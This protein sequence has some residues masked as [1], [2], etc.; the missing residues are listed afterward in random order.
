MKNRR[1]LLVIALTLMS[2]L[3]VSCQ[4]K[5]EEPNTTAGPNTTV[6]TTTTE[7]P[8]TT[9]NTQAPTTTT[10]APV[11]TTQAPVTNTQ[12]P[13][14]T[15]QDTGSDK[16]SIS[17]LM[18]GNSHSDDTNEWTWQILNDLGYKNILIGTMYIPGCTIEY[19]YFNAVNN[20]AYYE[21]RTTTTGP[22]AT[23]YDT[24][25]EY[26]IKY[27]D[28]DFISLQQY[29]GY[30]RNDIVDVDLDGLIEYVKSKATNPDVELIFNM[31]WSHKANI[32][33]ARQYFQNSMDIWYN[34]IVSLTEEK[35]M[36][37]DAFTRLV[38]NGTTVQNLTTKYPLEKIFR[39]DL[40]LSEYFGRYAASMTMAKVISGKSIDNASFK[41]DSMTD[42]EQ[43]DIITCVNEAVN[44][45]Y[46][47]IDATSEITKIKGTITDA[48]GVPQAGVN[49]FHDDVLLGS[50]DS[51]GKFIFN[52]YKPTSQYVISLDKYGYE[53]KQMTV[54]ANPEEKV[55]TMN[56]QITASEVTYDLND[57]TYVC[58][59][60]NPRFK[61][62]VRR[63]NN[64]L[65]FLFEGPTGSLDNVTG[66]GL[67]TFISTGI[68]GSSR[69][70]DSDAYGFQI[71]G[72]DT[73][74]LVVENLGGSNTSKCEGLGVIVDET[75]TK[76][77]AILSIPFKF[78]NQKLGAIIT[79]DSIVGF[80]F[81]T[82]IVNNAYSYGFDYND[83]SMNEYKNVDD[84]RTYLRID[85]ESNLFNS[86][87]NSKTSAESADFDLNE[88]KQIT[89]F[90]NPK[91]VSYVKRDDNAIY[92]AYIGSA[93][94][95]NSV[96]AC[97]LW[98]F[99][100]TY[101]PT[102]SRFT[103]QNAY[104]F[105]IR[106]KTI[107]ALIIESPAGN[108]DASKLQ[109]NVSEEDGILSVLFKIPYAFFNQK[110]GAT[111][112]KNSVIGVS[113]ATEIIAGGFNYGFDYNDGVTNEY[114]N[115]DDPTTYLRIDKS[116]NL[117][118]S[119]T[120]EPMN[121][122]QYEVFNNATLDS[123]PTLVKGWNNVK[124]S[125]DGITIDTMVFIP[126]SY[127]G[128]KEYPILTYLHGDGERGL[129]AYGVLCSSC[130]LPAQL[131]ESE[132]KETI[133]FI[134]A[135]P[136]S[137]ITVDRDRNGGSGPFQSYNYS[138]VVEAKQLTGSIAMLNK[139]MTVLKVDTNKVYLSGYSRGAFATYY[140]LAKYPSVITAA[141][142]CAGIG[143]KDKV[144]MFKDIPIYV[145][146][147]DKDDVV[148]YAD[149]H[150][151][152]EEYTTLGGEGI[153]KTCINGDHGIVSYMRAEDFIT[154]L[155]SKSKS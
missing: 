37:R 85:S 22:L 134:P 154:W 128:V 71:L 15:T 82:E 96:A 90:G 32:D 60:G 122:I 151:M 20:N 63:D 26:A 45:P 104:T 137:W 114:K 66:H 10:Q 139:L 13:V 109:L 30:Y 125:Y 18:I 116:C 123:F 55:L 149:D 9:N 34:N 11:T 1:I 107:G 132:I 51:E 62:Y 50:T 131:A 27:A 77:V 97:G 12:A 38:P 150:A 76:L 53:P 4:K 145:F 36:K 17:L 21:F 105:Q 130:A 40:H 24:T 93:G 91:F 88:F 59:F 148:S 120:N 69:F 67:W 47:Q 7:P 83:G 133:I 101:E 135:T 33:E 56:E 81:A 58:E 3:L 61:A 54:D 48:N 118:N 65:Y 142:V 99:I 39:D 44:N 52:I 29:T 95:L 19:H 23:R 108:T 64:G 153:F 31:T 2:I 110:Y 28:W 138:E 117:Y 144:S 152:F 74:Q 103:D 94:A 80:S 6:V 86:S 5:T 41:P 136:V 100:S 146:H 43:R 119:S 16:D 73:S 143:P 14:T 102:H 98:T 111:I 112:D 57:Y 79:K 89:T 115:V 25:L 35:I 113:F 72:K 147:G 68:P 141:V 126:E 8:I 140:L 78:F 87:T 106:G 75:N 155:Y 46:K 84:P 127:D 49:F 129:S 42:A 121:Q 70:T 92:F 124:L